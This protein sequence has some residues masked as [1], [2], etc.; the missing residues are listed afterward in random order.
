M[1]FIYL[2]ISLII[3][4]ISFIF[5]FCIIKLIISQNKYITRSIFIPYNDDINK[6]LQTMIQQRLIC[7]LTYNMNMN[8]SLYTDSKNRNRIKYN[9]FIDINKHIC[10]YNNTLITLTLDKSNNKLKC[11]SSFLS[12]K[13]LNYFC[14]YLIK[15]SLELPKNEQKIKIYHSITLPHIPIIWELFTTKPG[16][17]L[18][19]IYIEKNIKDNLIND[20]KDFLSSKYWYLQQNIPYRRSYLLYGPTGCGKSSLITSICSELNLD[21]YWV[22]LAKIKLTDDTLIRTLNSIPKGQLI[23]IEDID[24]AFTITKTPNISLSGLLRALDGPIAHTDH[25]VFFTANN[26]DKFKYT[27]LFRSGRIDYYIKMGFAK[28]NDILNMFK[29]FYANFNNKF[30]IDNLAI[31]YI[32][33]V[34]NEELPMCTIQNHLIINKNNPNNAV[35]TAN[36]LI[37]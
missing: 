20:I 30:D 34:P 25:I 23:L 11:N 17:T 22:S 3:S 36:N 28:H 8:W 2:Y 12:I 4:I 16:R 19:S 32:N 15:N 18:D 1:N 29:N 7:I 31:K 21:I 37:S 35:S 24:S 6:V 14:T 10:I 13:N 5:I 26:I 27:P 9:K 33:N